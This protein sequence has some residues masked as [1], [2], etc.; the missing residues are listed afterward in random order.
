LFKTNKRAQ[1]VSA[2]FYIHNG[3]HHILSNVKMIYETLSLNFEHFELIFVD[4]S[5]DD[6]SIEE[7]KKFTSTVN[8]CCS[9]RII[10]LG[11]YHGV[12]LSMQAGVSIAIGDF[13]Y[14]F[15]TINIDY[16]QNLIMQVFEEVE[17]GFDIVSAM[18]KNI[19]KL[20]SKVFYRVLKST[21]KG[22]QNIST[23][24]FRVLSRRGINRV[25]SISNKTFYRKLVYASSGLK[26][27]SI[28]YE[29]N[30]LK[31]KQDAVTMQHRR[32]MAIDTFI[33]F[34]DVAYRISLVLSAIM[35]L[36]MF[37]FGIYTII[38][39]FGTQRPVEG[40]A[41][42]MGLLSGGF[43]GIFILLSILIKYLDLIVK[44]MFNHNKF[45]ISSITKLK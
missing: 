45:L 31:N 37:G 44:N 40:W 4:D 7:I 22:E 11:N 20:Q 35:A 2:V 3:A 15:D 8:E 39:Y 41:P 27:T 1:F 9:I 42:I 26:T 36:L 24:S 32:N 29:N 30:I 33:I 10:E 5:S 17:K 19:N 38:I 13:V 6:C 34:T 25:N 16:P 18:P 12:E 28:A 21:L 23:E 43:F 14:E